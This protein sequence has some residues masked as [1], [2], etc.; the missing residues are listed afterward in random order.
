TPGG[1][2][3]RKLLLLILLPLLLLVVLWQRC[4][5][6]GCPNV[7]QL[8]AY[9]PGGES[10]LYDAQGKPF[11]ELTPIQ[12]DVVPLSSLPAYVPAAFV[13]VE[14]KRFYDHHGVDYRRFVGALVAN[15]KALRFVQGFST[16]TMQISGSVWRDRVPRQKK[17]IGR[18]LLEIRLA[19]A[20]ERRFTKDQI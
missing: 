18:K 7:G 14:D 2:R 15:L 8:T 6:R 10:I 16:I 9:Q 19:Y 4:G 12:H 3:W 11:A 13:A 5:L 17:T 1:R 20:L